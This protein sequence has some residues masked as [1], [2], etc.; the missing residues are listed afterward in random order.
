MMDIWKE[1]EHNEITH[2]GAHYLMTIH[3]LIGEEG[4]ARVS[5]VARSMHITPGSASIMIKSLKEKGY[6]EEDRNRFLRLTDEGNRLAQ[7]VSSH[8]QTLITFLHDVL[9]IDAEKAEIDACKIEHLISNE[10]GDR[11]VLFL[12]FLLSGESD[13]KAFLKMYWDTL[14]SELESA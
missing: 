2:S 8:R 4:Y 1:F 5:D 12:K 14:E 7:S 9:H 3:K 11:M 6:L 10:T 13:A